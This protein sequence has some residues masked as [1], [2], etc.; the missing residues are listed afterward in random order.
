MKS[1]QI[2]H[3]WTND[4]LNLQGFY[5]TSSL[6]ESCVICVHGMSGNIIENY[7]AEVLGN[8]LSTNGYGFIYGHNRGYGHVNDIKTTNIQENGSNET[9]RI[10]SSFE[11]FEESKH[12][13]EIWVNEAI[14]L[15]Y[16]KIVLMGHSLGCNK[17]IHYLS[18]NKISNISKIILASPPD[19]VGLAKIEKYQPNYSEMLE[20]AKTNIKNNKPKK[21]LSS[22]LW[23]SYN[24]S[25]ETFLNFFQDNNSIDNL[26]LLR[27]PEKFEQLSKI[28]VPIFAFMGENDDIAINTLEKDINQI[29]EKAIN[30]PDFQTAILKGANHVY[31]NKE[32]ELSQ[33]IINWLNK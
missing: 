23:E 17:V 8:E 9:K 4:G 6:K 11:L 14:K 29:K 24:I 7:F 25:S 30:C 13:I 5:W 33:M 22:M 18:E 19:M 15:G 12:D 28:N 1:V 20:E 26:P 21:I 3:G 32:K 10:G 16:K 2:I 31:G 27:N